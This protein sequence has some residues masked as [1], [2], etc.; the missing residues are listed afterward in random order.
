MDRLAATAGM[1]RRTFLR[2]FQDATGTTPAEWL[3][4]LRLHLVKDLLE[5]TRLSVEDIATRGGFGAASTLR[6]HF[7]QRLGMTPQAYRQRF[8]AVS[9][10]IDARSAPLAIGV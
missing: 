5:T 6:H 9:E 1:S 10:G 4:S 2:R 8:S 3:L 7:R